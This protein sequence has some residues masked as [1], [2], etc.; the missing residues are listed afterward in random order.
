MI[1]FICNH[2][3]LLLNE[4]GKKTIVSI[5]FILNISGKII[6]WPVKCPLRTNLMMEQSEI[7]MSQND[8]MLIAS[9]NDTGIIGWTRWTANVADSA[10]KKFMKRRKIVKSVCCSLSHSWIKVRIAFYAHTNFARSMLSLNGKNASDA[11]AT[12]VNLEAHC[13]RSSA[14][15]NSGTSSNIDL[16]W[17]SGKSF[18]I[19]PSTK[20]SMALEISARLTPALNFID[21]TRGWCRSHQLSLLSPA[22]R[23][24]WIRDCCPAP[25]PMT[26]PSR[27]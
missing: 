25:M 23:V 9:L 21:K 6:C 11:K 1:F 13:L 15:K 19:V 18:P 24:Q 16:N 5:Y 7:G 10:L 26:W 2:L 12:P 4:K 20:L 17:A 27:A 3:L 14:V 22:R 8:S